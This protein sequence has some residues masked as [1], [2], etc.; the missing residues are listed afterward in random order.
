VSKWPS[1]SVISG[2]VRVRGQRRV[3]DELT[4]ARQLQVDNRTGNSTSN[5]DTSQV[6]MA[7][8]KTAI[9]P[10]ETRRDHAGSADG[11]CFNFVFANPGDRAVADIPHFEK[12]P[13]SVTMLAAL[14]ENT[15][16]NFQEDVTRHTVRSRVRPCN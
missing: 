5:I 2:K 8:G 11:K 3:L 16:L 14:K 12:I 13:F 6:E 9:F 4:V 7:A 10:G 1:G 15:D